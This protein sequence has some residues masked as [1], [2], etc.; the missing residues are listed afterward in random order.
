MK[1]YMPTFF[2][3]TLDDM[4]QHGGE[5]SSSLVVQLV[6]VDTHTHHQTAEQTHTR[7]EYQGRRD[8]LSS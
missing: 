4:V 6:R 5:R 8:I 3:G 7:L 2:L 1:L